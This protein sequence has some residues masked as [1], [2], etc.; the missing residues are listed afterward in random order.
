MQASK[1]HD[2]GES[3]EWPNL[4]FANPEDAMEHAHVLRED[5]HAVS[6][7]LETHLGAQVPRYLFELIHKSYTELI[8]KS[9]HQLAIRTKKGEPQGPGKT[10]IAGPSQTSSHVKA[11]EP[12]K[13]KEQ[14]THAHKNEGAFTQKQPSEANRQGVP[15]CLSFCITITDEKVVRRL[16]HMK[17]C[18]LRCLVCHVANKSPL[19]FDAPEGRPW[20]SNVLQFDNGDLEVKCHTYEE[21]SCFL[22]P[23]SW[24]TAVESFVTPYGYAVVMKDVS[25]TK[26]KLHKMTETA[27]TDTIRQLYDANLSIPSLKRA[28]DIRNIRWLE[29]EEGG[30]RFE[31]SHSGAK[32]HSTATMRQMVVEFARATQANTA[33]KEGLKFDGDTHDCERFIPNDAVERCIDCLDFG[34]QAFPCSFGPRCSRCLAGHRNSVCSGMGQACTYC[35][36]RHRH[37]GQICK[38]LQKSLHAAKNMIRAKEPL[39]KLPSNGLRRKPSEVIMQAVAADTENAEVVE[40]PPTTKPSSVSKAVKTSSKKERSAEQDLMVSGALAEED[41]PPLRPQ[42]QTSGPADILR[43]LDDI[44]T[45]VLRQ[46]SGRLDAMT[47]LSKTPEKTSKKRKAAEE[48]QD[49]QHARFTRGHKRSKHDKSDKA[50]KPKVSPKNSLENYI[51]DNKCIPVEEGESLQDALMRAGHVKHR[52]RPVGNGTWYLWTMSKPM[53]K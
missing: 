38:P 26:L 41:Q 3:P 22:R 30:T 36:L 42:S 10:V 15:P 43:Q 28:T 39:W 53:E 18:E 25:A 40:V 46:A 16:R 13:V 52:R 24:S 35:N 27:R 1:T 20:I 34:H 47:P 37:A 50:Y 51:R 2:D 8:G 6:V 31:V 29:L 19:S 17:A 4:D 32:K 7:V 23:G 45:L 9:T 12:C 11:H 33:I 5:F 14:H 44:R 49:D 48:A 21:L